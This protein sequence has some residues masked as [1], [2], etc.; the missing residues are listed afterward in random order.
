MAHSKEQLAELAA[1]AAKLRTEAH[2]LEVEQLTLNEHDSTEGDRHWMLGT[3][4]RLLREEA[5]RVYASVLDAMEDE[6]K[7]GP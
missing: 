4:I 7:N 1:H 6:I 2:R 3:K 5:N